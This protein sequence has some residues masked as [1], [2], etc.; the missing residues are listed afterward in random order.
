MSFSVLHS[1]TSSFKTENTISFPFKHHDIPPCRFRALPL[2]W[3]NSL[4]YRCLSA[5]CFSST[6][7]L[8]QEQANW[9]TSNPAKDSNTVI[10]LKSWCFIKVPIPRHNETLLSLL[11]YFLS[12]RIIEKTLNIWTKYNLKLR[13]EKSKKKKIPIYYMQGF[14]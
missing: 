7:W 11:Y 13:K 6:W 14:H 9:I 8:W 1:V 3:I 12:P 10:P 5:L 2:N 4:F